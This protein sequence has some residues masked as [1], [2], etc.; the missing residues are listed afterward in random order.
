MARR[1]LPDWLPKTGK[2]PGREPGTPSDLDLLVG[3]AGFD[4]TRATIT[5]PE[6]PATLDARARLAHWTGEA[7]RRP[8]AQDQYA[9]LLPVDERV[10]GPEHPA[11][12]TDRHEIARW[13]GRAD[14]GPQRY[15]K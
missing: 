14:G 2:G 11:T 7:G 5:C 15:V 4:W 12:L 3:T 6:Y 9:A 1:W 13:T 8:G 10:L